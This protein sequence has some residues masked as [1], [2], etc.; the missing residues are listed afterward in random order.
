M[1]AGKALFEIMPESQAEYLR[2]NKYLAKWTG[3]SR[4]EA[5]RL[6]SRG[7]VRINGALVTKLGTLVDTKNDKVK[8]NNKLVQVRH[9]PFVYFMF[10]KPKKVLTTRSDS[11]NRPIVMDYFTKVKQSIFPVGRLDWLSE[12][13]LL[14]TNDG[15]FSQSVLHPKNEIYKTYLVKVSRKLTASHVQKLLKGVTTPRGRL[16]ADYVKQQ[17]G[18]SQ[19]HTWVKIIVSEGKNRQVRFMLQ[20][21]DLLVDRL[22]RVGIGRL[23]LSRLKPGDFIQLDKKDLKKIFLK[24]KELVK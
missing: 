4:R 18:S 6:V 16:R 23:N 21:L 22:K 20:K 14:L 8:V 15:D 3:V 9:I 11:K 2:I 17:P 12:G 10:N 13:L 1:I 5:D 19:N 24:P 7:S